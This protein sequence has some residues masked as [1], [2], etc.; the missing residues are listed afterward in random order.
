[1]RDIVGWRTTGLLWALVLGGCSTGNFDAYKDSISKFQTA[2]IQTSAVTAGYFDDLNDFERRLTLAQLRSD[3]K[4]PL[5]VPNQFLRDPFDPRAIEI[6]K[7]SFQVILSYTDLLAQLAGSDAPQRWQ[8]S[9]AK[10]KD[11]AGGL[12]STVS[13][14]AGSTD[15]EEKAIATQA[16]GLLAPLQILLSFAGT[17]IINLERTKALDRAIK[18]ASPAIVQLS[19]ALKD[20]MGT[21]YAQRVT[22]VLDPIARLSIAYTQA[23]EAGNESQRLK[24]LGDLETMLANRQKQLADLRK[25]QTALDTFDRA[26]SAL[27]A[28]AESDKGPQTLAELINEVERYAVVAQSAYDAL[29]QANKTGAS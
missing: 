22:V 2:T 20:D 25:I 18:T 7:Q 13:K 19:A 10:L 21:V 16:E 11:S 14:L 9:T 24:L 4:M 5:D 17:E 29:T 23:Q 1:M 12:I 28:Y 6:R 15:K 8:A 27:V 3:P 26:H